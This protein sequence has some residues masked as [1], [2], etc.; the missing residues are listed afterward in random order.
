MKNKLTY[1]DAL[2][3]LKEG[4]MVCR[5]GWN[6][7]GMF[8]FKQIPAEIGLDVI[9]RMTSV[10]QSVKNRML[11]KGITLKYNNQMALVQSDGSVDSWIA[12]SSDT[13]AKDWCI[14]EK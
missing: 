8:V 1:N 11:E 2:E 4:K 6:G 14:L 9:P 5:E 12:S 13:F 10:P 3:A 7:K